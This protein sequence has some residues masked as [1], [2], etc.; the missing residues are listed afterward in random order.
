MYKLLT[1]KGQLF[2]LLLGLVCIAIFL[3]TVLS[4]ISG[5]GYSVSDDLNQIMKNNPAAD[6]SFFNPGITVVLVLIAV[7]L[8]FAVLFGLFQLVSSPKSSMKGILG[9]V[10]IVAIFFITYNMAGSDISGPIAE[11]LQKFSVSE[12]ISKLIGGGMVTTGILGGLAFIL[13][14]VFEIFNLFK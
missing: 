3:G 11:T 13:L 7:A 9:A 6:F 12:N 1:D 4:G 10:A 5:A 2:A 8:I 14:I